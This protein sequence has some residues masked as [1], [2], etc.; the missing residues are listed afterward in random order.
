MTP[1]LWLGIM[2]GVD[3]AIIGSALGEYVQKRWATRTGAGIWI[4][5]GNSLLGGTVLKES[6]L[7][8]VFG[9]ACE[10]G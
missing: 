6:L 7:G 4:K 2:N 1:Q 3:G 10:A 8:T 5:Y 9:G